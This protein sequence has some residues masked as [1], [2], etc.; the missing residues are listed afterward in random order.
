MPGNRH[1]G[2][3]PSVSVL[4]IQHEKTACFLKTD[5]FFISLT[6]RLPDPM[7][8]TGRASAGTRAALLRTFS[9]QAAAKDAGIFFPAEDILSCENFS[10]KRMAR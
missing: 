5:R 4:K 8:R 6:L 1:E 7:R 10:D 2:S 3:N 9:N